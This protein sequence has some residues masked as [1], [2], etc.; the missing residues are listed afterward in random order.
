MNI[1][2][3]SVGA[4][5]EALYFTQSVLA[6]QEKALKA[7]YYTM[8]NANP[9]IRLLAPEAN[10][11]FPQAK[12]VPPKAKSSAAPA[13]RKP[14]AK[15]ATGDGKPTASRRSRAPSK[16]KVPEFASKAKSKD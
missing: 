16:P 15:A 5:F 8:L 1:A 10:G 3:I 11:T 13:K 9:M 12:P 4:T 6:R 2:A 14:A 7:A